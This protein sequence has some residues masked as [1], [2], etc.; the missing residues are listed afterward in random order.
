MTILKSLKV[1]SD[2]DYSKELGLVWQKISDKKLIPE[3]C[4][5][6]LEKRVEENVKILCGFKISMK[7]T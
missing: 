2:K 5:S 6:C 3:C 7:S 4:K 1:E